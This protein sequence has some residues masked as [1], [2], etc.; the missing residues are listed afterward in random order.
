MQT[1]S[2]VKTINKQLG[3]V[4]GLNSI[5]LFDYAPPL[6]LPNNYIEVLRNRYIKNLKAYTSIN[7]TSAVPIPDFKF[8]DS[9]TEKLSKV[10]ESEWASQRKQLDIK[11][12]ND[13][14]QS[15]IS[16]VSLTKSNGY[17][18][19]IYNLLDLM[20][21]N[22]AFEAGT[23]DS[24][25]IQAVDVGYGLLTQQDI[26]NVYGSYV[27][28]IVVRV[29]ESIIGYINE[30]TFPLTANQSE[31]ISVASDLKKYVLIQN[32]SNADIY[33]SFNQLVNISNGIKLSSMGTYELNTKNTPYYGD[34]YALCE[35][36][37][38]VLVIEGF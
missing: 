20:T 30:T 37:N 6:N 16:S 10:I 12:S 19:R 24:V 21:D 38:S 1:I 18:F 31:T 3:G 35:T 32:K 34:I 29:A 5:D 7:S 22:L 15:I 27:E 28:E 17:P 8:E 13:G 25:I 23:T 33:L 14:I 9:E 26:V 36:N 4:S 11:I 2:T